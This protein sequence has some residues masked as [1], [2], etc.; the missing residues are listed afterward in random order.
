[1]IGAALLVVGLLA[2]VTWGVRAF[3]SAE[4]A[5]ASR[6]AT[7]EPFRPEARAVLAGLVITKYPDVFGDNTDAEVVAAGEATC[8]AL[9]AGATADDVF[10]RIA[11]ESSGRREAAA[12]GYLAGAAVTILCPEHEA[13]LLGPTS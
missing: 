1:M 12:F 11:V 3:A 13:A 5:S 4:D 9:A 6:T 10:Y 7:T 2:V 8:A